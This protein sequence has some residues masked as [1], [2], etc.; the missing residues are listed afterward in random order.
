M[1]PIIILAL[2][3]TGVI[4]IECDTGPVFNRNTEG[5]YIC[6]DCVYK[7]L[8]GDVN[9]LTIILIFDT[10]VDVNYIVD[11]NSTSHIQVGRAGW[12][13]TMKWNEYHR[14]EIVLTGMDHCAKVK[15]FKLWPCHNDIHPPAVE[16]ESS[17]IVVRMISSSVVLIVVIVALIALC[18]AGIIVLDRWYTCR[19]PQCAG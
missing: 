9:C 14:M 19:N 15:Q 17:G 18:V 2:L 3:A 13:W 11:G 7:Y 8:I 4:A 1:Y 10:P 12:M 5:K 16:Y 6:A